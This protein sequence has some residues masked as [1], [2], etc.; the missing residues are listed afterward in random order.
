M[1]D[2]NFWATSRLPGISGP[3][4]PLENGSLLTYFLAS[5]KSSWMDS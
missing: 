3:F 1:K 2:S 4:E 5:V